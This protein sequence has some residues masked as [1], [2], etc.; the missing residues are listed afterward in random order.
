MATRGRK[1]AG[2]KEANLADQAGFVFNA[3]LEVGAVAP[4]ETSQPPRNRNAQP[5]AKPHFH[6]HRARLRARFQEAGP[7]ALADYELLELL[8]F[9]IIPRQDTKPLAKALID[10]FG[11]IAGV[12]AADPARLAETTGAGPAVALE[13]KVLQAVLERVIRTQAKKRPV[14]SSWSDLLAYCRVALQHET[15]EHFRILFL[16]AKNCLIADET[17]GIGST[18]EAPVY[19]REVARRALE[20]GASSLIL[21]HNHPSGD[22][23]PSPADVAITREV[24]AALKILGIA[25]HDHLVVARQGV[26]SFK[27]LGLL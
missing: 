23:K 4:L 12:L 13:L 24:A 26:A 17:Q 11:D 9:R 27:S 3:D 6:D 25:L 7:G 21:V 18:S 10:R 16:D 22:P 1:A 5:N 14:V 19:P 2:P 20:L 15:R 8:L